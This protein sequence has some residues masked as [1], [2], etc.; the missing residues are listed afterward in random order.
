M[1]AMLRNENTAQA[2]KAPSIVVVS[3]TKRR[4]TSAE[5]FVVGIAALELG[6]AAMYAWQRRFRRH[7]DLVWRLHVKRRL[8]MQSGNET[9]TDITCH[10]TLEE[11]AAALV[12]K[13]VEP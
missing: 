6:A 2:T 5:W 10:P 9:M 1:S 13:L 4:M 3:E 11:Q 7:G 8:G 12:Q